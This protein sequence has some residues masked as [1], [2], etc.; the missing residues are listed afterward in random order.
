[1]TSPEHSLV[2]I[3]T[4]FALGLHLRWK[5][6][7]VV[8]AAIGSN[9][10]DLDGLPMLF[11]MQ[12]F[13]GWHRVVGH[14]IFAIV[15]SSFM[16]AWTQHH[17][18]WIQWFGQ[19][20]GR[21]LPQLNSASGSANIST[22]TCSAPIPWSMLLLVAIGVQLIHLP[23]DMVV[24]GGNGL[25]HWEVYPFWPV[26]DQGFVYPMIPWGD[27]GPTI[28][29]MLGVIGMAKWPAATRKLALATLGTLLLYL[30]IRKT[31]L[32]GSS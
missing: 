13:E 8:F 10:P 28:I 15:I 3:H 22:D 7:I 24:S 1:M 18:R 25:S 11:D 23:C 4:A 20:I 32:S 19:T 2:G 29:M 21:W 16:L 6:P 31:M 26:N 12:R 14:N 30:L 5:W 17:F 27:V 9:V